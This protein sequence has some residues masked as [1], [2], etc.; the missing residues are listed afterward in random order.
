MPDASPTLPR[1][2][3]LLNAPFIAAIWLYRITLSRLTGRFCRFHPTCSQYALEAYHTYPPLRATRLT[4]GRLV[5]CQPL[6]RGGYD[7]LPL[8][9]TPRLDDTPRFD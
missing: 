4:L 9:N 8:P 7:P 5:R 1:W 6:A 3:R 2:A